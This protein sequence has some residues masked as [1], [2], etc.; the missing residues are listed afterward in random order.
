MILMGAFAMLLSGCRQ[1]VDLSAV[2]TMAAQTAASSESFDAISADFY[3]SCLR[4]MQ[5]RNHFDISECAEQQKASRLWQTTN[6]ILLSYIA[7]LGDLATDKQTDFGIGNLTSAVAG[8]NGVHL[9]AAQQTSIVDAGKGLLSAIFAA[10]RRDALAT[11][12]TDAETPDPVHG[13]PDG[14]LIDLVNQLSQIAQNDY[15]GGVLGAE[16]GSIQLFYTNNISLAEATP[17]PAPRTK[18]KSPRKAA[19]RLAM[20]SMQVNSLTA[21]GRLIAIRYYSD[22]ASARHA[23]VN[24]RAAAK[25]YVSALNQILAAHHSI[26]TAIRDNRP[27]AIAGIAQSFISTYS[28]QLLEIKKAFQ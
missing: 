25:T 7:S 20:L 13:C 26:V 2:K 12:M 23:L 27:D 10:K 4:R 22:E 1:S 17:A 15:V 28:A 14:C 5:Y 8:I 9:T 18:S 19:Q 6:S 21:L 11:V 16:D 3:D 24:R